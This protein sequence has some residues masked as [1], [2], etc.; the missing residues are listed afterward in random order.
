MRKPTTNMFRY[1]RYSCLYL[2]PKDEY[3]YLKSDCE[4]NQDTDPDSSS[5]GYTNDD[6]RKNI[7][8]VNNIRVTKGANV[9]I[10]GERDQINST[11]PLPQEEGGEEREEEE[12]EVSWGSNIENEPRDKWREEEEALTRSKKSKN[13]KKKKTANPPVIGE[14]VSFPAIREETQMHSNLPLQMKR[15]SDVEEEPYWSFP[16]GYGRRGPIRSPNYYRNNTFSS[17]STRSPNNSYRSSSPSLLNSSS[18][19]EQASRRDVTMRTVSSY[20]SIRSTAS[21]KSSRRSTRTESS[22]D[23]YEPE[24]GRRY[25][26][27][28]TASSSYAPSTSTKITQASKPPPPPAM[29][30]NDADMSLVAPSVSKRRGRTNNDYLRQ[31]VMDRLE[32]LR[33]KKRRPPS[34]VASSQ[35]TASL[36]PPPEK[37]PTPIYK[38]PLGKRNNP[39]PERTPYKKRKSSHQSEENE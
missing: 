26:V 15:G 4:N 35:R 17:T 34:S 9:I 3:E 7:H 1:N 39:F 28:S 37:R 22:S 10:R 13:K 18:N 27:S 8:Q 24:R 36:R 25:S 16:E 14:N 2:V 31:I 21:K 19:S 38:F 33:G 6:D 11:A 12:K 20:P 23:D 30:D 32:T 29:S 5:D